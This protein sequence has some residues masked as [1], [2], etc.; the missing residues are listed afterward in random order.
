MN[1]S[2]FASLY[3]HWIWVG[4]P[5]FLLALAGLIGS[6][7]G[8]VATLRKAHLFK[9]PLS[10]KQ[11]LEF[12]EPGRVVLST[13]GPR[14]STRFAHLKFE[15]RGINGD[16]VL[17]RRALFRAQTSGISTVRTEH[18][19]FEIPRPGRY[20]LT[21]SGPGSTRETDAGH[22]IVFMRPHLMRAMTFVIGIVVSSAFLI[23]SLVFFV[24]R[25]REATPQA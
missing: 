15:L 23:A 19:I 20:V 22:S 2:T 21:I 14:F 17:G 12:R 3:R 4:P 5:V 11:E 8:V 24:L 25:V 16:P 18:L 7:M 13:E 1:D 6:I 9:L 10:E